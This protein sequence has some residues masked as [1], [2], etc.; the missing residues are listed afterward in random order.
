[1]A[2]QVLD[3]VVAQVEAFQLGQ[4]TDGLGQR[5]EEVLAKLQRLQLR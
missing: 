1:M 4:A 3:L 2:G 5:L